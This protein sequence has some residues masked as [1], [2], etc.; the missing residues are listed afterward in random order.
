MEAYGLFRSLL[1][2]CPALS[3]CIAF[4][5]PLNTQELFKPLFL[6][7]LN[8][9]HFYKST[10]CSNCLSMFLKYPLQIATSLLLEGPDGGDTKASPWLQSFPNPQTHPNIQTHSLGTRLPP[11]SPEQGTHSGNTGYHFLECYLSRRVGWTRRS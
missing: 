5:M 11:L 6:K 7:C 3:T 1:R 10:V 9:Q 4:V 8:A 2:M